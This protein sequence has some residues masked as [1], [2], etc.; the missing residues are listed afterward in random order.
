LVR[1]AVL[2]EQG[3]PLEVRDIDLPEPG[4][5][6]VRVRMVAAGVCHS[7]LSLANGTLKQPVPAVLGHE[8]AGIVAS[9]GEGVT[10]V[11]PGDHVILNWAPACG[12][13]WFCGQ[14]EPWLCEHASDAAAVPYAKLDG[15]DLY[16][17][18]GAGAFA[19]ETI[20]PERGAVKIPRD[21]PLDGAAVLGCAVL[22]GAGAV[23]NTAAVKAGQS[24]V[25]I[26]L[27]GIGLSV[28]QAARIAGASPIVAVDVSAEKQELARAHGAT[29]FVLSGKDAAKAVRNATRGRGAD[30][31]FECVGRPETIRLAWSASRRGGDVV[32]VGVGSAKAPVEFSA[33]E[34]Y[35]FGRTLQGCLFGSSNPD[36]DVPK[37]LDHVAAGE[38]DL[39][40]LVTGQTDLDGINAAFEQMSAGH[41]ARTLVRMDADA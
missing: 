39:S 36:V 8:G 30:H 6:Q 40:A 23:F 37:L 4:P 16:P 19:E 41:G 5:G 21:V 29:D 32:V 35:W 18:L 17:A 31:A 11:A 38:L 3:K 2:T 33:L 27:G 7:D 15:V 22:T 13:C 20:V 25:V 34:L 1:A 26:G 14:G 10:R 9:V 12:D 28:L 24:V